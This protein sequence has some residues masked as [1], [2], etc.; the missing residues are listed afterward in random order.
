MLDLTT[1]QTIWTMF[2]IP[3]AIMLAR[4]CDVTIGTLRII[5]VA[6]GMKLLAPILEPVP[7]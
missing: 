2:I 4:I 3:L 7:I 6:R 5:F 1:E